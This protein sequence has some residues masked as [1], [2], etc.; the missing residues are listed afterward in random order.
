MPLSEY[1]NWEYYD[2]SSQYQVKLVRSW[3]TSEREKYFELFN[4]KYTESSYNQRYWFANFDDDSIPKLMI[5]DFMN[6]TEKES[7]G[8]SGDD[9]TFPYQSDLK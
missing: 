7:Y 2:Y 3:N 8:W 6:K 1:R 5:W 4:K 9:L